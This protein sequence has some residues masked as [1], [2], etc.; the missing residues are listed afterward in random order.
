LN[1]TAGTHTLRAWTD[2]P[3]GSTDADATNDTISSG[4]FC[5]V[6][7]GSFTINAAGSG[8]T[9]F[10]TFTSAINALTCAGINGAVTFNV[11]NGTYNESIVLPAITGSSATNTVTFVSA[12]GVASNVIL[13]GQAAQ[14]YTVQM[15]GASNV[16]FR[17][18]SFTISTNAA[19]TTSNILFNGGSNFNT[20]DSCIF[21]GT[22]AV[23]TKYHVYD[24][25]ASA[26]HQ[27]T[28]TNNTFGAN[29]SGIYLASTPSDRQPI[30]SNNTFNSISTVAIYVSTSDSAIIN[31]NVINATTLTTFNGIQLI[32]CNNG[33]VVSNN[34]ISGFNG[35]NGINIGKG[36]SINY[37]LIN[38]STI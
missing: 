8:A 34:M 22:A 3:N 11:A 15:N 25:A 6:M 19:A 35:G 36:S 33:P 13:A 31:K 28:F 4:S 14:L 26:N 12:S 38:N 17:K 21:N 5:S 20:F 37:V 16:S 24:V 2:S 7:S 18:M 1:L 9:N 30:I 29:G 23:T 32:T 27:N 10:T